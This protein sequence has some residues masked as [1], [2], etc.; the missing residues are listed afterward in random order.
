MRLEKINVL[1][2]VLAVYCVCF[3]FRIYEYF[4]LRTDQSFWGEAF[5]H[6]LIGIGI[7]GLV[8]QACSL[9]ARSI[10]FTREHIMRPILA[11]LG[12]GAVV[13]AI[14]YAA[15][16]ALLP[17]TEFRSLDV[18]VSTYAVSSNTGHQTALIFFVICLVGNVI[19]V[20]MEEG[21]FRGLFQK[22]L[23]SRYSF[24]GAAVIS[25]VLFGLW[26]VIAPVR[27]YTD[28]TSSLG[29]A[30]MNALILMLTSALVGFKFALM[31]RLTGSLYMAMANHCANNV[32]VN[33]VHVT[34]V[35][36]EDTLMF[37]RISI[38]QGL[39]FLVVAVWYLVASRRGSLP[40]AGIEGAPPS[41]VQP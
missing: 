23:G 33:L 14:A 2:C 39:S 27:N 31:T 20:V 32:I 13:F 18:Y 40:A 3:I 30:V 10:G 41:H 1:Y 28:G 4:V 35:S 16:I 6:K 22:L 26:H 9:R 24:M 36:G 29:G 8:M 5:V 25:S 37:V 21:V 19:N 11:G 34:S 12:F 38:A 7:L 15:E 17:P